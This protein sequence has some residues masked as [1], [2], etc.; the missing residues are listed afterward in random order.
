MQQ[1]PRAQG[2]EAQLPPH[3]KVLGMVQVAGVVPVAQD[4]VTL[5]QQTPV[6]GDGEQVP[7]Q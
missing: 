6:Q 3:K 1:A 4:P 7:L 5:L 2:V